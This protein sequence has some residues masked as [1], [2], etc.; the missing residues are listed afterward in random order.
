M[1]VR[2]HAPSARTLLLLM[3]QHADLEGCLCR[4]RRLWGQ[5]KGEKEEQ[6]VDE[7]QTRARYDFTE[8]GKSSALNS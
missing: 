6:S 5:T 1:H 8:N 2:Q 3:I 4:S 7:C